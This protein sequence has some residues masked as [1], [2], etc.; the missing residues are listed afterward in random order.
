MVGIN[1]MTGRWYYGLWSFTLE[2][3]LPIRRRSSTLVCSPIF[4][5]NLVP[6]DS[7]RINLHATHERGIMPAGSTR[8]DPLDINR[9]SRPNQFISPPNIDLLFFGRKIFPGYNLKLNLKISKFC[10]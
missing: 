8:L 5:A 10:E 4:D 2:T 7:N 9:K 6:N 3:D 1:G